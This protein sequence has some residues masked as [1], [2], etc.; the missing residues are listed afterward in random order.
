MEKKGTTPPPS[1]KEKKSDYKAGETYILSE[2]TSIDLIR[3]I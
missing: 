3:M 1:K 2:H